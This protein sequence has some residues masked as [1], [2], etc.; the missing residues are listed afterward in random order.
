MHSDFKK[1]TIFSIE[2]IALM[3]CFH[4]YAIQTKIHQRKKK[5]LDNISEKTLAK[6][7][8]IIDNLGRVKK[9]K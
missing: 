5:N 2:S 7:Y 3:L 8:D 1:I 4:F 9:Q 6:L